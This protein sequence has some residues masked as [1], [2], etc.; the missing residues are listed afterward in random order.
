[1]DCS[2]RTTSAHGTVLWTAPELLLGRECTSKADVFSFAV[3]MYEIFTGH[4]PYESPHIATPVV[5]S[6]VASGRLRPAIPIDMP[7]AVSDLLKFCWK[8][9]HTKRPSFLELIGMLD[10]AYKI[11]RNSGKIL[12][13]DEERRRP[14]VVTLK[15]EEDVTTITSEAKD[16]LDGINENENKLLTPLLENPSVV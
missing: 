9:D 2:S 12:I 4:L 5:I 3:V 16:E 11:C 13:S 14:S 7:K 6:Q 15:E 1:M 8:Q 10:K